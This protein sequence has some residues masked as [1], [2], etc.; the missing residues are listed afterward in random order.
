MQRYTDVTQEQLYL[1]LLIRGDLNKKESS[2]MASEFC[3][4][5][6]KA[7]KSAG[8]ATSVFS[9]VTVSA[10]SSNVFTE[11]ANAVASATTSK[12]RNLNPF[13]NDF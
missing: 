11:A 8:Q 3:P 2:D 6:G 5:S 1:L 4:E 7:S 13:G 12:E 9:Q 10:T